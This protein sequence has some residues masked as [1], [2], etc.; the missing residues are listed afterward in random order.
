MVKEKDILSIQNIDL[1]EVTHGRKKGVEENVKQKIII[2][3]LKLLGFDIKDMDFEHNIRNKR[4]DI[5]IL[6]DKKPKLIVECKSIE[7]NLDKHIEQAL[8]YAIN[9]QVP[10]VILT[11]GIEFRIYKS[12]MENITNSK[13]RLL[14]SVKLKNLL[15]S[16]SELCE[17][18]SKKSIKSKR[19]DK[20][21]KTREEEITLEISAP[22]LLENLKRAKNILM[23]NCKPKIEHKYDTD[24]DFREKVDKWICDSEL[25][26]KNEKEW[27]DKLAK[28]VTYTFINRLYFYRIAE[29]YKIV[30]PKLTKSVLPELLKSFSIKQIIKSGFTEI[31]EIDYKAIFDHNL[32]DRIDFD[33]SV[34]ERVVFQLSEYNF[35]NINADILGKIY[36]QHISKQERKSLGQFYTP[37]WIINFIIKGIPISL[38]KTILDPACGSGGFLIQVYD[39]LK[40]KC[41]KAGFRKS[42]IHNKILKNNIFG[43]D[44]NP[45]AVQLTAINLVLKDLKARTD[46]IRILEKDSLSNGLDEWS[47]KHGKDLD[48]QSKLISIE[49]EY[50]KKFDIVVGNPPY[51]NLKISQIKNKYPNEGFEVISTGK[52][53]IASLFLKKYIDR[54]KEN[55]HLGFVVPK[56]LTYVE[57]WEPIRKYILENSQIKTVYDL[58]EAFEGVKLEEI[59]IILKKGKPQNKDPPIDIHYKYYTKKGLIEKHHKVKHSLFNDKCFPLYAYEINSNI[60]FKIEKDATL[61]GSFCDITRGAYLQKYKSILTDHKTTENDIMVMSGKNIGVYT[62]RDYKYVNLQ[63]RRV[64]EFDNKI[65]RILKERIVAQRLVAQT[66]NH[67]KIIATYDRGNNLNVDTVINIIQKKNKFKYKYLL[68]ILNSKLASYYLFN[69]VYNR[70]VR[71]M[72]FEYVKNL[73]IKNISSFKQ[74]EISKDVDKLL[75]LSR[76]RYETTEK[77]CLQKEIKET[78]QELDK[79]IYKIY[80]LSPKE[81]EE[82]E[83]L[84]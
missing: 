40:E 69:F 50:P 58:R 44:I 73:P 38:D 39:I 81:I 25:D 5:A 3:I 59:I 15:E 14:F 6:A 66:R 41:K 29:D 49:S 11:N 18:V 9:K 48:N 12:F 56:S 54:L 20:L 79:Q 83:N 10:F 16:W 70:A 19:I 74:G 51:F 57:P 26:I 77:E 42:E 64:R 62:Y 71:S 72:N 45:F 28:E 27:I 35:R 63:N 78:M 84:D 23:E 24:E 32:F 76:E 36:E 17:W 46:T 52:T 47:I 80:E 43:Y 60:K 82:I 4:A 75:R 1:D 8:E 22:S 53:N 30:K 55:G 68:A 67:I 2:P 31:L 61:L 7:Q 34:L 13:D 37:E 65:K 33:N 21:S